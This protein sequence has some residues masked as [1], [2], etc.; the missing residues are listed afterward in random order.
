M[1]RAVSG[2]DVALRAPRP[3]EAERRGAAL[4]SHGAQQARNAEGVIGVEVGDEHVLDR[5]A[6]GVA[7]HLALG[8][9]AAIEQQQLAL[10]LHHQ[11]RNVAIH[12]RHRSAGTEEGHLHHRW[13]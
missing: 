4:Q 5:E 2:A 12:R 11:R 10:A 13:P 3:V 6:R 1:P 8:S 7:H 9:L